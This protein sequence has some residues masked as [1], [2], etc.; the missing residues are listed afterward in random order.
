MPLAFAAVYILWGSTFLG[1]RIAIETIPPLAMAAMRHSL[2]GLIL[3][4][5]L[6]VKTGIRPTAAHWWTAAVTGVSLLCI[7]NGGLSWAE[8]RVPSGIAALLIAT[9]SLWLVI[10]DWLRPR[11]TRPGPRVIVGLVVGFA[12]MALLVGP[13][14]LGGARRI[15]VVGAGVLVVASFVWACASLYSKQRTMPAS[16]LL[17]VAMQSLAGGA[18]LWIAA[19]VSGEFRAV[20]LAAI[21][22]RS[23]MA[24][25]Y[26]LVFGSGMGFTAYLYILKNSTASKVATYAF[27]NPV[28]ALFLGWTLAGETITTRTAIA[29]AVILTAVVLVISAPPAQVA[30]VGDD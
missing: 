11:G 21:S 19:I 18:A 9:I 30:E 4:P 13:A 7:S 8:Q 20:H 23:W 5:I 16:P 3:Y 6:R 28:V 15:D 29:A 14:K 25:I 26:L 24:L 17:V 10:L 22:G 27:V 1:I 12:G 2:V